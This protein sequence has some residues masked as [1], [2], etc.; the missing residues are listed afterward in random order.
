MNTGLPG[1]FINEQ[2]KVVD[3]INES[4]K[5]CQEQALVGRKDCSFSLSLRLKYFF[6]FR[7]TQPRLVGLVFAQISQ[8]FKEGRF[9]LSLQEEAHLASIVLYLQRGSYDKTKFRPAWLSQFRGASE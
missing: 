9:D 7:K 4:I 8:E 1:Q 5:Q 2:S 6:P 3:Y